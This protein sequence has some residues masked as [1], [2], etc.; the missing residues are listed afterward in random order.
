MIHL[1]LCAISNSHCRNWQDWNLRLA[2]RTAFNAA[3]NYYCREL[4]IGTHEST[5]PI[6]YADRDTQDILYG[7]GEDEY[8]DADYESDVRSQDQRE[9][10]KDAYRPT[11]LGFQ[12]PSDKPM[13]GVRARKSRNKKAMLRTMGADG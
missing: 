1:P 2:R 10:P 7:D 4:G 6:V 3:V 8:Y 11:C 12:P 13:A 5:I 9:E